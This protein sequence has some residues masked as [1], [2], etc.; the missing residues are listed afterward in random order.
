M[1]ILHVSNFNLRTNKMRLET[2]EKN[3]KNSTYR[4]KNYK[5]TILIIKF[6]LTVCEYFDTYLLFK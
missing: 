1:K 4:N 5:N 3:N 6:Y 2:K